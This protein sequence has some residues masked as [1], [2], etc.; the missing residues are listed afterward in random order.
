M[1]TAEKRTRMSGHERREQILDVAHRIIDAEGFHAATPNRI[2]DE[3]GVT[4][5][6][7]Y[8]QFGDIAGLFVALIDREAGRAAMHAA[9]AVMTPEGEDPFIS[10]FRTILQAIDDHPATWRLLL[11]PPAGAPP[12]LH[13]RLQVAE[14][15]AR[16]FLEQ[17]LI[18]TFPGHPDPEYSARMIHAAGRELFLQRLLDPEHATAERLLALVE[19]LRDWVRPT[20]G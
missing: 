11:V 16:S 17:A 4:R 3:A 6:V 12:E 5:P 2:A 1:Q 7:L 14:D 8:Q 13:E 15:T 18:E 20:P 10:S 19:R 9:E